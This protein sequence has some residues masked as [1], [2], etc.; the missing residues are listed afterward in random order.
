MRP[1]GSAPVSRTMPSG[2]PAF[3]LKFTPPPLAFGRSSSRARPHCGRLLPACAPRPGGG[4][5]VVTAAETPLAA[6]LR[7][8][9]ARTLQAPTAR[10]VPA[11]AGPPRATAIFTGLPAHWQLG[12]CERR[13]RAQ[14]H[15]GSSMDIGQHSHPPIMIDSQ[16]PQSA[17]AVGSLTECSSKPFC[18]L[19]LHGTDP[20]PAEIAAFFLWNSFSGIGGC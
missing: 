14:A 15:G 6:G 10:P 13:G 5:L 17:L 19:A 4:C 3:K 2:V 7:W 8:Q 1:R 20:G 16:G 12:R 9:M 18:G 11:P